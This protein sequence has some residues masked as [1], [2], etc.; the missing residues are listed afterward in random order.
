MLN[1][2]FRVLVNG[3]LSRAK[4]IISELTANTDVPLCFEDSM[5]EEDTGGLPIKALYFDTNDKTVRIDWTDMDFMK[6]V[7]PETFVQKVAQEWPK[8]SPEAHYDRVVAWDDVNDNLD[9]PVCMGYLID[10][11]PQLAFPY[12]VRDREG[13]EERFMHIVVIGLNQKR[14]VTLEALMIPEKR[15]RKG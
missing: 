14:A 8:G 15:L 2:D 1:K 9:N 4:R 11:N 7:T 6:E 3:D 5:L 10:Y 13:D 12:L